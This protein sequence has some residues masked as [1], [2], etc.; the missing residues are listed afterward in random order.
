MTA[1]TSSSTKWGIPRALV[2][3]TFPVPGMHLGGF[4]LISRCADHPFAERWIAKPEHVGMRETHERRALLYRV[5]TPSAREARP[6]TLDHDHV[7]RADQTTIKSGPGRWLLAEYPGRWGDVF[8][9]ASI[10][11]SRETGGCRPV[12]AALLAQHLLSA[13]VH[14]HNAGVC[15]GPISADEILVSPTGGA[16]IEL[17]ALRRRLR[18]EIDFDDE[19]A[20]AEVASI[21]SLAIALAP[22]DAHTRDARP[23]H[24]WANAVVERS[25]VDGIDARTALDDLVASMKLPH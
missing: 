17:Y 22:A 15:H 21:A 4:T 11:R 10:A 9:L 19:G 14:A 8:T 20:S 5:T 25:P 1:P 23:L 6:A 12:E 24:R 3:P 2:E 18:G 13:S 16:L 7:L